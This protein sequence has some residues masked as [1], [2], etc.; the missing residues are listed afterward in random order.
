MLEVFFSKAIFFG[1]LIGLIHV[2][3]GREEDNTGD[4]PDEMLS[5]RRFATDRCPSKRLNVYSTLGYLVFV[6]EVLKGTPEMDQ[7]LGS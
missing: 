5:E 7:I 4:V 1:W 3:I 6:R 2:E